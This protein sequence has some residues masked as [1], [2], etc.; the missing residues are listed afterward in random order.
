[1]AAIAIAII[2]PADAAAQSNAQ[3][4]HNDEKFNYSDLYV[5]NNN[6]YENTN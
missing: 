2:L 1:M 4:A 6:E 3:N 5:S